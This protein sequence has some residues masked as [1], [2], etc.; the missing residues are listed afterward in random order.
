MTEKK[1]VPKV[2]KADVPRILVP[3][4]VTFATAAEY[5]AAKAAEEQAVVTTTRSFKCLPW[6]GALAVRRVLEREYSATKDNVAFD[7]RVQRG[8]YE[9][10]VP[11]RTGPVSLWWGLWVIAGLGT[12]WE[13]MEYSEHVLTFQLQVKA[14][15]IDAD[16]VEVLLAA[17]QQE[18]LARELYAGVALMLKPDSD[19]DLELMEP[20][21]VVKL[22]PLTMDDV[23]LEAEMARAVRAELFA[24]I[25]KAE[26]LAKR[27]VPTRRGVLLVGPPGT[28]KSMSATIAANLALAAGW[29][30]FYLPDS[31]AFETALAV[32]AS[33][34]PALLVV[35][36]IDRQLSGDRDAMTDRI[37]NALSGLD[38]SQR[39]IVV[40]TSNDA[41]DLP[42]ALLRP[43]RLDSV[44]RFGKPDAV[45]AAFLLRK[46]LGVHAPGNL[47]DLEQA[48]NVCAGLLP[49]CIKEVA[50]RSILH[51][52]VR[53]EDKPDLED[54]EVSAM[55]VRDQQLLLEEQE[56]AKFRMPSSEVRVVVETPPDQRLHAEGVAAALPFGAYKGL[57]G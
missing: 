51:A 54:I 34:E 8:G 9:K 50:T 30:V 19:G 48:G 4:Q 57:K 10:D 14:K 3:T 47:E 7:P 56:K 12:A 16:K 1:I 13:H 44:L 11:G 53:E 23:V 42:A 35:E 21:P 24:P 55:S 25:T 52:A 43:G 32:A 31:R 29:T 15:R 18:V 5:C 40:C 41:S 22:D 20:P 49:A 28:G 2:E 36:D 39:L 26:Q 27:G 33:H 45:A 46:Y 17:V 37:L 38:S 6:E